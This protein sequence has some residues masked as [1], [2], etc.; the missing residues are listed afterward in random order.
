MK[1]NRTMRF[2]NICSLS[3]L[4]SCALQAASVTLSPIYVSIGPNANTP[5]PSYGG[6][7]AN[8]QAG[9]SGGGVDVGGNMATTPTAYN[10]VGSG[11]TVTVSN[12]SIIG[13]PFPSWLSVAP[14][15]LASLAG[16]TGNMLYWSVIIS[17]GPGNTINL[18]TLNVTQISNDPLDSFGDGAGGLF[19][20][21]YA[22]AS[23]AADHV[24]VLANG[25]T[26]TSGAGTQLV[27]S[28]VL[29]SFS[30]FLDPGILSADTGVTF[31][32]T[33]AQQMKQMDDAFSFYLGNF[34]INTC[35]YYGDPAGA[36]TPST[37]DSVNV[38][39]AVNV[40]TP[41]PASFGSVILT[42]SMLPLVWMFR[43]RRRA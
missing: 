10:V 26:V 21:S 15:T 40:V 18:D 39:K 4:V 19:S 12:S 5:S 41:E 33:D 43:R 42:L 7:T 9:V 25:T 29:T 11:G 13:T 31:S 1:F 20:A 28:I 2:I 27:N 34:A 22:G 30:A 3:I 6:Y 23:Y 14:P 24:G 16:E 8:A 35:F 17:G 32:G 37:C 36:G 38:V